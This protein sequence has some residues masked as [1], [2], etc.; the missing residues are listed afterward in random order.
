[1]DL[2]IGAGALTMAGLLIT[3]ITGEILFGVVV[4]FGETVLQAIDFGD[5]THI[6]ILFITIGLGMVVFM[7][8]TGIIVSGITIDFTETINLIEGLLII[9][10]EII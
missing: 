3:G 5:E 6:G 7:E 10:E 2:T 8:I 1:M 4:L 9:R